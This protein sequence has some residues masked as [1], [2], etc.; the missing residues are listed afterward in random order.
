M[1]YKVEDSTVLPTARLEKEDGIDACC[2]SLV[3]LYIR[4]VDVAGDGR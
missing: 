3:L 1:P 4:F 2:S